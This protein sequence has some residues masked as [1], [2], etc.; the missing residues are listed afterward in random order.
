[1]NVLR[2]ASPAARRVR[3]I[4]RELML[5]RPS[6][7]EPSSLHRTRAVIELLAL[8]ADAGVSETPPVGPSQAGA[9]TRS[10]FLAAVAEL[11]ENDERIAIS[12]S[13]FA[14]ELGLSER[15]VSRLVRLELDTTF[16]AYMTKLRVGHARRL[17]EASELPV[18]QIAA[19][20][21]WSSLAHFNSVFRRL[22]G[23]TPTAYRASAARPQ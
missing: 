11:D 19:E 15:Q 3:Q 13:V 9:A 14:E 5:P 2:A 16:C 7:E 20:T 18:I 8:A 17:L 1:V 23:C 4:L 6:E 22:T 12:L 21:G 10:A